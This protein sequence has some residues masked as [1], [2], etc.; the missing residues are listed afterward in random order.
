METW[1]VPAVALAILH[2]DR[3]PLVR[4][5]GVRDIATGVRVDERT[6]F[7][8]CSLTKSLTAAGVVLL[9]DE[10]RLPL[11]TKVADLLP[12][13][14]LSDPEVTK[15][16]NVRDLLC[17]AS[18]LPRHDRIW[19]PGDLSRREMVDRMRHLALSSGLRERFQYNNLGYVVLACI[20]ERLAGRNW[21]EYM[22]DSFLR[23]LGFRDF[24]WSPPELEH[25][26]NHAHPHPRER[27]RIYRGNLWSVPA[28][29]GGLTASIADMALWLG[30]L[31]HTELPGIAQNRWQRAL[32]AMTTPWMYADGEAS[33]PEVGPWH[34][35]LGVCCQSYRGRRM[36]VH[37]G[38]MPG[39]GSLLAWLPKERTGIVVLTNRDPSAVPQMLALSLFDSVCGLEN[40]DWYSRLSILRSKALAEELAQHANDGKQPA[41][42]PKRELVAYVGRFAEPAYGTVLVSLQ[43]GEL[44]WGWRGLR[45]PMHLQADEVFVM[46]E[47]P[48]ARHGTGFVA[49]F[50]GDGAN[51]IDRLEIPHEPE[52]SPI[53]FRRML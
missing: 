36:I 11:T 23:P 50:R 34:Y 35:G 43:D 3:A 38:S 49:T 19:T 5:W 15:Q 17:H 21:E 28:S 2:G 4:T 27:D 7:S 51:E 39:W 46:R 44:H 8:T 26:G 48:P 18:G 13:F 6:R 40:I 14:S 41:P 30:S 31:L 20:V 10:R 42:A 16:L 37:T 12:D 1:Q 32:A 9:L 52:V 33:H 24:G 29:C 47:A 22:T 45:G 25:E 53:V